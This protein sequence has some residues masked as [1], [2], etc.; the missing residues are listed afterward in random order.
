MEGL[1]KYVYQNGEWFWQLPMV[2]TI[3]SLF[4]G[5]LFL[6]FVGSFKEHSNH[7][8]SNLIQKVL[9]LA[10]CI[11][12]QFQHFHVVYH[13]LLFL[14][15][16]IGY[17]L[18]SHSCNW[19]EALFSST[20]FC[21]IVESAKQLTKDGPMVSL[22]V[23]LS[24]GTFGSFQNILLLVLYLL[25][26]CVG[27]FIIR[28]QLLCHESLNISGPQTIY[29]SFPLVLY[30]LVRNLQFLY[31][32]GDDY[33][34]I[35]LQMVQMVSAVCALLLI[36]TTEK[37]L[38]IEKERNELM[39]MELLLQQRQQQY[40]VQ[41]ETME[42]INSKY[43]DLKHYLAG[44]EALHLNE[45]Q[46]YVKAMRQE[47]EPFERYQE[48]G[49]EVLDIL[50]TEKIQEC[51]E[52]HIR[53]TPFIDGRHLE[54]IHSLDLCAIFGNAIDNAIEAV[55][56]LSDSTLKEIQVKIGI[57]D[58]I[59]FFRF[60]NYFD[61][62]LKQNSKQ[63]LTRK[64]KDDEHGYGLKNIR[65]LAEK[66]GGTAAYD[67]HGKEFTLTVMLPLPDGYSYESTD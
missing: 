44:I 29:L 47:I 57:S 45:V 10:L 55:E 16:W 9:F 22:I 31:M 65:R 24:P 37:N 58:Q 51:Q 59:V 60:H 42:I 39:K 50:L 34:W 1:W 63:L 28:T 15:L 21:L 61:G 48:T 18:L 27:T 67:A 20:V 6:W 56:R 38:S 5:C 17:L 64:S 3:L 12:L 30:L 46:D 52:K 40:L 7:L 11:F 19:K 43:H 13:C 66:Y 2:V 35:Y 8:W 33:L 53:L 26:V 62:T 14:V 4:E 25:L 32:G 54:F 23:L 49:S 41:K 36:V